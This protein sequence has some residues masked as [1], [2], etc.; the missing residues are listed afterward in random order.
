MEAKA[1]FGPPGTGKTTTLIGIAEAQALKHKV[2]YLS[3]TK[4]AATEAA[5]RTQIKGIEAS[6]LH[7]LAYRFLNVSRAQVVDREKLAQ[8]S[9]LVGIPIK[10]SEQNTMDEI[11]EG[12]HYL[13]VI[14]YANNKQLDLHEAYEQHN[15][16]GTMPRFEMFESAYAKFK[17]EFGYIDFDDMLLKFLSMSQRHRPSIPPTVILDEAQDCSPLQWDVFTRIATLA[18]HVWIA[19][20]DD[21]AIYEWNGA[22]PHGMIQFA[23]DY[24]GGDIEVLDKSHRVPIDV[25]TMVDNTIIPQFENRVHK[26]FAPASRM[27][28][29]VQYGSSF[30]F[31]FRK[32]IGRDAKI[33]VRDRFN[34]MVIQ[35]QLNAELVPYK[36][37]GGWSPYYNRKVNAIRAINKLNRGD[38]PTEAEMH[39]MMDTCKLGGNPEA[40]VIGQTWQRLVPMSARDRDFYEAAD[41]DAPITIELSTVH[42]SKG[43]EADVVVVDLT[44][45]DSVV[46]NIERNRD[47]ELRVWY[48]ACTRTRDELHLL[49]QNPLL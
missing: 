1:I 31:D 17:K 36:V 19:G 4:A 35:R 9:N 25:K 28:S 39:A 20:D 3:Y 10:G 18:K 24:G 40:Q 38:Q 2:L 37:A 43:K 45:T 8:F 16:P 14:Q 5:S 27:G 29:V 42:Q 32:L 33:L 46:Q 6:T 7:S 15:R 26:D 34:G 23:G 11:Q 47:S 49:S 12:D 22:D 21:Q 48:V 41:L 30:D 44:V 13:S